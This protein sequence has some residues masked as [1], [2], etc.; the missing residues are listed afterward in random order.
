MIKVSDVV[1]HIYFFFDKGVFL[2]E[3][4]NASFVTMLQMTNKSF[5]IILPSNIMI[6]YLKIVNH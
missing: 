2:S 4:P 6:K 5:A 1:N 3:I